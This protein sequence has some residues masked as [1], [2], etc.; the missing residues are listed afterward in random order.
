MRLLAKV[1]TVVAE[2]TQ[3]I[4]TAILVIFV[5]LR[6]RYVVRIRLVVVTLVTEYLVVTLGSIM[7]RLLA[8]RTLVSLVTKRML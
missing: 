3:A 4:G 8:A 6:A 2:P 7:S 5:V 1:P